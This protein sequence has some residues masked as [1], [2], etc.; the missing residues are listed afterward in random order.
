MPQ[1]KI[2]MELTSINERILLTDFDSTNNKFDGL[3]FN[4]NLTEEENDRFLLSFQ[5]VGN[6][7]RNKE[8]PLG[9]LIAI[10]RPI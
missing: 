3:T 5:L 4:E 6:S 9:K 2:E 10:G 8:I 1:F 7:G